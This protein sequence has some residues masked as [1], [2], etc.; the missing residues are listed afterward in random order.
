MVHAFSWSRL[1]S[2]VVSVVEGASA[3]RTL[4]ALGDVLGKGLSPFPC[5]LLRAPG[6]LC[7]SPPGLRRPHI[8]VLVRVLGEGIAVCNGWVW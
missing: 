6:T 5:Y 2:A 7:I 4:W 8:R 3:A 1:Y